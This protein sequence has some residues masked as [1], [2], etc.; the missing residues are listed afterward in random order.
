MVPGDG[1]DRLTRVELF[2][3]PFRVLLPAGHPR[4][5]GA[6]PIPLATLAD[7]T[8]IGGRT[9]SVWFRIVRHACR[10]AGFEPR[11][12]LA[13]DDYRAVQAF[14]GAGLGVAVV[15]GLAAERPLP[16]VVVRELVAAPVRRV[17]AARPVGDPVLPQVRLMTDLLIEATAGRRTGGRSSTAAAR[18]T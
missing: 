17:S 3:D 8:W 7:E 2:D 1:S 5:A 9:G 16:G 11:T 4:A 18:R 6:G 13:T 15:P 12:V 10:G 14:V